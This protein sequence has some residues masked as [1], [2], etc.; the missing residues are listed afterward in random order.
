MTAAAAPG[1][2]TAAAVVAFGVRNLVVAHRVAAVAAAV[3][4]VVRTEGL[5]MGRSL[6]S[7]A[8]VEVAFA[9][10]GAGS[11]SR[12]PAVGSTGDL[13]VVGSSRATQRMFAAGT[14]TAAEG[15]VAAVVAAAAAAAGS[16][17]AAAA[18]V[19]GRGTAAAAAGAA[20]VVNTVAVGSWAAEA[21]SQ[22]PSGSGSPV[23]SQWFTPKKSLRKKWEKKLINYKAIHLLWHHSPVFTF[24]AVRMVLH[25]RCTREQHCRVPVRLGWQLM[26]PTHQRSRALVLPDRARARLEWFG[27]LNFGGL[28]GPSGR[29]GYFGCETRHCCARPASTAIPLSPSE[30]GARTTK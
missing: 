30:S 4:G 13:A 8:R 23:N 7:E 10:E 19:A 12:K 3:V 24:W 22:P 5:K 25:P 15:R 26:Q 27:T 16:M 18:V 11:S 29:E 9:P 2:R 1:R 14:D 21:N 20:A 6:G 17:T 28:V